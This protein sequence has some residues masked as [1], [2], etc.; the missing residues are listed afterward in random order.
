MVMQTV[1]DEGTEWTAADERAARA[2]AAETDMK[3][4]EKEERTPIQAQKEKEAKD[5]AVRNALKMNQ[6]APNKTHK[7]RKTRVSRGGRWTRR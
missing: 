4:R 1:G 3:R 5:E 6:P 2:K 7:T